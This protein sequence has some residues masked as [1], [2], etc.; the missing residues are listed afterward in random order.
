MAPSIDE[1]QNLVHLDAAIKECLRSY[2]PVPLV[3]RQLNKDVILS[4]DTFIHKGTSVHFPSIRFSTNGVGLGLR[5]H[6]LQ[7]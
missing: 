4:D 5:R 3:S 1:L 2:P 6:A 7:A